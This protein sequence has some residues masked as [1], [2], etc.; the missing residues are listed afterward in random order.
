VNSEVGGC[1]ACKWQKQERQLSSSLLALYSERSERLANLDIDAAIETG[2][3][4]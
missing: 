4:P 3:D 1:A 2:N